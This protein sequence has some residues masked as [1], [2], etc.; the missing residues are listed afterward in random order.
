MD[1]KGFI[2]LNVEQFLHDH[3]YAIGGIAAG[4]IVV[5]AYCLFMVL[6]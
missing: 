4:A 2:I 3:R 5:A 1:L 6:R